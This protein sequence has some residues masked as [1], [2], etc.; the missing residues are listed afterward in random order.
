ME[1]N[2]KYKT[3]GSFWQRKEKLIADNTVSKFSTIMGNF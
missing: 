1:K 2:L 3:I